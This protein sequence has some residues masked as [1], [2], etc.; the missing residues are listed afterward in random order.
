MSNKNIY[1]RADQLPTYI[2][3]VP[4]YYN[5]SNPISSINKLNYN[6]NR[7]GNAKQTK[8]N[9]NYN[10]NSN[11]AG[12][13]HQLKDSADQQKLPITV[14][15]IKGVSSIT[16][17][18][19]RKDACENCGAMT[20]TKRDCFERPRAKGAR[21]TGENLQNDEYIIERDL[22]FEGAHDTWNGYD[23]DSHKKLVLEHQYVQEQK[24]K[25]QLK[26]LEKLTEEDIVKAAQGNKGTIQEKSS[27]KDTEGLGETKDVKGFKGKEASEEKEKSKSFAVEQLLIKDEDN[28][29]EFSE[30]DYNEENMLEEL[31]LKKLIDENH[32]QNALTRPLSKSSHLIDDYKKYMLSLNTGNEGGGIHDKTNN[33]DQ[34][35]ISKEYNLKKELYD[36]NSGEA[37]KFLESEEFVKKANERNK[38]LNLNP[39]AVPTQ[40]EMYKKYYKDQKK[41]LIDEKINKVLSKYG[42]HEHME[43]PDEIK[44]RI[45]T[46]KYNEYTETGAVKPKNE[47]LEKKAI[48]KKAPCVRGHTCAWGSFYHKILGWGY[49]CCYS[50]DFT[51]LCKGEKHKSYNLKL[52]QLAEEADKNKALSENTMLSKKREESS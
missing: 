41:Q 4:W 22:S 30:N 33:A 39:V 9:N 3:Q 21:F 7:N 37:I 2:S 46:V 1:N 40:V 35:L 34:Q 52:I 49:K 14:S 15:T 8:Y 48:I 10:L 42:G 23:P 25:A 11:H 44:E 43:V 47:I 36:R 51:S 50:F 29:S 28:K 31:N 18:K 17:S 38:D 20:H 16:N 27:S 45:D 12:L 26:E 13:C 32:F 19:F 24:L 6:S 5:Q